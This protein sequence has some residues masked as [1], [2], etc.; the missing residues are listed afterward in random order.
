MPRFRELCSP[1]MYPITPNNAYILSEFV[2]WL[3]LL[4]YFTDY[5]I[6]CS[7]RARMPK[8]NR[9]ELF[10]FKFSLPPD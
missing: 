7:M 3:L 4:R 8:L 2:L 9:K 1:D 10:N 6:R 5:A